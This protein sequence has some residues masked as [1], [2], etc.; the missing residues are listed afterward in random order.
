VEPLENQLPRRAHESVS[1]NSSIQL[2]GQMSDPTGTDAQHP[3]LVTAA[4]PPAPPR[5]SV[6]GTDDEHPALV[7]RP[8]EDPPRR[9]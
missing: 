2:M 3:A 7:T 4:G 8:G 1:G 5:P 9:G 6:T